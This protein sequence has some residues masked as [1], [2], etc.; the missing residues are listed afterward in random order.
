M[1]P[2]FAR[3]SLNNFLSN[4]TNLFP[5]L[6]NFL[7]TLGLA[8]TTAPVKNG[9]F[10]NKKAKGSSRIPPTIFG[11]CNA[12]NPMNPAPVANLTASEV[13][14]IPNAAAPALATP[15]TPASAFPN[16]NPSPNA[17]GAKTAALTLRCFFATAS[18][19]V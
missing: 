17:T 9:A 13:P 11:V 4:L 12:I 3:V 18:I 7:T 14:F 15:A 6:L 1:L 5:A 19:N 8:P 16:I 2:A 10:S